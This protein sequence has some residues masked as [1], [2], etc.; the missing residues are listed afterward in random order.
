[1]GNPFHKDAKVVDGIH[2]PHFKEYADAAARTSDAGLLV[3]DISKLS[4]QL[5][6]G[7]L[8]RLD[9]NVGPVWVDIGIGPTGPTGP[10]GLGFMPPLIAGRWYDGV[11]TF[12]VL[13]TT[14]YPANNLRAVMVHNPGDSQDFDT[15]AVEQTNATAG[16]GRI[17]IYNDNNGVPGSLV[18]DAGLF[19]T[20]S[21]GAKELAIVEALASGRYWL[22]VVDNSGRSY[23]RN[24]N[25][26]NA[27]IHGYNVSTDLSKYLMFERAF[28][29]GALPDPFGAGAFV[30]TNPIR[31]LWRP[32]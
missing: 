18:V 19:D 6:N 25:I 23:R 1:M 31:I 12:D 22:A 15:L 3:T 14:A 26:E 2:I 32:A 7:R 28:T 20:S 13:G 9:N 10:A 29:F 30:T 5:D 17:G 16:N 24:A 11:Y 27:D 21:S 4:L 8:F